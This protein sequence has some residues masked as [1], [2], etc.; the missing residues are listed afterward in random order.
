[1]QSIHQTLDSLK[2]Q[3]AP[4]RQAR[5]K[6]PPKPLDNPEI[7][8][9]MVLPLPEITPGN[10]DSR[11]YYGFPITD[12][13][14]VAYCDSIAHRFENYPDDANLDLKVTIA[15]TVLSRDTGIDLSYHHVFPPDE[16]PLSNPSGPTSSFVIL[17]VCNSRWTSYYNRPSQ[18]QVDKLKSALGVEPGWFIDTTLMP[19]HCRFT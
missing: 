5:T 7:P 3:E 4:K 2:L 9:Q 18:D 1:M 12:D 14:I 10:K 16:D 13:L 11:M 17:T 6:K 8:N 19:S 15:R